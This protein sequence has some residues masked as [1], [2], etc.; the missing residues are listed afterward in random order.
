MSEQKERSVN[1][2]QDLKSMN[3]ELE[4]EISSIK[5]QMAQVERERDEAEEKCLL[6]EQ[7]KN[8]FQILQDSFDSL[9]RNQEN[10]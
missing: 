3:L 9:K 10:H 4:E 6:H 2:L 7:N 8:T 1:D 5:N